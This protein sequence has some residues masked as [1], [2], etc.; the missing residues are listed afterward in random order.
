MPG[1]KEEYAAEK[2]VQYQSK[3]GDKQ[4]G[5]SQCLRSTAELEDKDEVGKDTEHLGYKHKSGILPVSAEVVCQEEHTED[6]DYL[7][8]VHP[9]EQIKVPC[10]S[11]KDVHI[12]E[13]DHFP[14]KSGKKQFS[15]HLQYILTNLISKAILNI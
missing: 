10:G 9:H 6:G 11:C 5:G 1:Y 2:Q 3:A 12:Q 4:G 7:L 15:H 14:Q 8:G 13:P